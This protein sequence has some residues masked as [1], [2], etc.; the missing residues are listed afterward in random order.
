MRTGDLYNGNYVES[1]APFPCDICDEYLM[2]A[3][4]CEHPRF[5]LALANMNPHTAIPWPA[6]LMPQPVAVP[7]GGRS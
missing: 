6:E 2:C 4:H 7:E 5:C 3:C 1:T